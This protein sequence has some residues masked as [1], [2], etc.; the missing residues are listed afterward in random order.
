L[1]VYLLFFLVLAALVYQMLAL[2]CLGRFFSRPFSPGSAPPRPGITVFKPL[3]SL[4][5]TTREGLESFLTQDYHPYQ[6]VFGLRDPGDPL[7]PLLQELKRSFPRPRVDIVIC[8]ENLG[9]NP[10]V[11]TLRQLEPHALYDLLVIAD[12]D[13]KVGASFLSRVAAS[14]LE[15]GVGLVSCPYRAGPAKSLGAGLE[16][17]T[18]A[19]DFIPSVAVALYVEGVRF[20]LGAA[21]GLSRQVLAAIG[22]FAG[23]A[24]FLADDYQLGWRVAQAGYGVRLL[25]HVVETLDPHMGFKDFLKH[26]LR[27]ARTY[28]VCRPRGYLAYGV[29]H[30]LVY[31]AAL[32]LA[33]GL[34][35]W[36][37][38]LLGATLA[39]RAVLAYFSERLTLQG[40]LP[41]FFFLLLPLKDF[42]AWGVWLLS[43]LGSRV[44]WG[45]LTYRVTREGKLV[46][47]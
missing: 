28:R 27:W 12:A 3:K 15:P 18:I 33:S 43:F 44:T 47:E 23:L 9:L 20:A 11:N 32:Y 25:P 2:F 21:M 35:P 8:P 6:V 45:D 46:P 37:L 19:A 5:E 7:L 4:A 30:A 1:V 16:A 17:L 31:S 29:T 24:D 26:Q 38:G 13:V 36:A 34:A 14:L 42:L 22:G 39:L 40:E 41:G 10:K